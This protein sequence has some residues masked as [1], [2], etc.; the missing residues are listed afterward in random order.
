M[1]KSRSKKVKKVP[2][3]QPKVEK[4]LGR[5]VA[6]MAETDD[7]FDTMMSALDWHFHVSRC[8]EHS[9]EE[10]ANAFHAAYAGFIAFTSGDLAMDAEAN[11]PTSTAVH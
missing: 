2:E 7:P 4:H 9:R 5:S 6:M 10:R 1:M 11:A 3:P 8:R